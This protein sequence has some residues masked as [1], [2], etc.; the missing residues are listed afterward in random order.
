ME[1]DLEML[2]GTWTIVHLEMDGRKMSGGAA[3]IVVRG[4]RFTTIAMGAAYEG[5]VVVHQ[6]TAPKSFELHFEQGPEKGNTNLGIYELDGDTWRICLATR[7]SERPN[8]FAA[9]PGTGI[10]METLQRGTAAEVTGFACAG[11]ALDEPLCSEA[12]MTLGLV[13][14]AKYATTGTNDVATSLLDLIPDHEAILMANHGVVTFGKSLLDAY[15][16]M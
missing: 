16:R 15:R 4:N 8:E 11:R 2:Q 5:T 9:P 7:G 12:L 13:P 3:R 1:R 14:L 6:T 10:A